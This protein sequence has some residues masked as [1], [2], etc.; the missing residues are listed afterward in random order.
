ME[1]WP[2]DSPQAWIDDFGH[3]IAERYRRIEEALEGTLRRLAE[4][5]LDAPDDTIA[6]Y[7]AIRELREQAER[8]VKQVNPDEL[9]RWATEE[10]ASGASSEIA[11]VLVDFPAYAARGVSQVTALTAGGA[12]AVAAVELDLRDSLRALNARILRAP[13]DA[14]QAMTSKHVGSLLTGMTT[15]Q[16]LHRRILDEYLADGITG[17]VDKADR[18]WTIGAY[19]EMATRTA[20]A[21][22]W[23]DQSVASMTAAGITTFTPVIGVSA[24]SACGAWAGKIVTDGGPTGTI[25][26]PHAITGEPTEI[27][28]DGTLD[29][30]RASG[31]GHPNCRC[32]LVPGLPGGPDPTQYTTHD[33][34]AQQDREH[35]RELERDV[36]SAKRDGGPDEI[37][38]AQAALRAH[39][40]DTG[41]IRREFREQLPFADGGTKNPRG[42]TKPTPPKSRERMTWGERQR[43]L[44]FPTGAG[45]DLDPHEIEF[46]ERFTDSGHSVKLI[47][48]SLDGKPTND[49]IW[50]SNGAIQV[51]VKKTKNKNSSIVDRISKAVTSAWENHGFVKD[52]FIIDLQDF[53]ASPGLL[54]QLGK[55]NDHRTPE[56]R[57][58]ELWVFSRGILHRVVLKTEK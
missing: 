14:Y 45:W 30:M 58:R 57:I 15:S 16:A 2:G 4:Q 44:G 20:A 8:L 9:A 3:A 31:W 43:A 7:N 21:R 56:R 18:R 49:F 32:V 1:Q 17:F 52:R 26:V 33:P 47:A 46:Y 23:R 50:R 53:P 54:N 27:T 5:H 38:A 39:V 24:C 34:Q 48:K 51:E 13:V 28:V 11:R 6:R 10:A 12:Y 35:L 37:G 25:T 41:L 36:R 29:E 55:Y 22:A 19:S 42:N 40:R